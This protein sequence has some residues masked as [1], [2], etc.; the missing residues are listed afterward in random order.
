MSDANMSVNSLIQLLAFDILPCCRLSFCY[1]GVSLERSTL[2]KH[3]QGASVCPS[4]SHC[5]LNTLKNGLITTFN[6]SL[7][8]KQ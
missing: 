2:P 5:K 8:A 7:D 4:V 6:D 3:R 1:V